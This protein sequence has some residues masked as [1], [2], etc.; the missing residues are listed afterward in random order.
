MTGSLSQW[1]YRTPGSLSEFS[2]I[3]NSRAV[4]TG[5]THCS[6]GLSKQRYV[7]RNVVLIKA[8]IRLNRIWALIN[9][10]YY[11]VIS[12]MIYPIRRKQPWH[13]WFNAKYSIAKLIQ[14]CYI[15]FNRKHPLQSG[16]LSR[17]VFSLL[18]QAA[19]PVAGHDRIGIFIAC[20]SYR[21]RQARLSEISEGCHPVMGAFEK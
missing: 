10:H 7:S 9:V 17:T 12:L 16:C 1:N 14:L 11:V 21:C 6:S 2:S 8:K 3:L 19:Y 18:S 15:V 13:T 20:Y 4:Q 5:H